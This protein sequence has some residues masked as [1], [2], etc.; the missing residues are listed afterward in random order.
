MLLIYG[1]L[2][3]DLSLLL[4]AALLWAEDREVGW[5]IVCLKG[6]QVT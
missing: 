6:S 4:R 1:E 5:Q 2:P 3:M